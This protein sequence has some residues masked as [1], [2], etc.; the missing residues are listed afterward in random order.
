MSHVSKAKEVPR[1]TYHSDK[2]FNRM[3]GSSKAIKEQVNGKQGSG[4]TTLSPDDAPTAPEG[5]VE[6]W[7]QMRAKLG[8][9]KLKG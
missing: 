8:L 4:G 1:K 3:F 2:A 5:S 6:Y 7:N 9:S